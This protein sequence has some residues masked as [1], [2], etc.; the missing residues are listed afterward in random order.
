MARAPKTVADMV[1]GLLGKGWSKQQ[2]AQRTG[3]TVR[4]QTDALNGRRPGEKY[5]DAVRTAARAGG[6]R[7]PAAGKPVAPV[8]GAPGAGHVE[9]R[10]DST[11]KK[12]TNVK[13]TKTTDP[14]LIRQKLKAA[15]HKKISFMVTGAGVTR[16]S[17]AKQREAEYEL[18]GKGGI[19]A[20][21]FL[22]R[23][24]NPGAD[25]SW[26]AGDLFGAIEGLSLQ[27]HQVDSIDRVTGIEFDL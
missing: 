8:K 2:V 24:D 18:F 14:A 3:M 16:Y 7:P 19:D 1:R 5:T 25:D 17:G 20:A 21:N 12:H 22:D 13:A 15:R 23:V 27:T 6:G 10:T 11:G 4:A 26:K 9:T